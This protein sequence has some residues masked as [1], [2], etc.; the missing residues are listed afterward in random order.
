M[1]R[2]CDLLL[3]KAK[4]KDRSLVALV[5]SYKGS[6]FHEVARRFRSRVKPNPVTDNNAALKKIHE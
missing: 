2:G 3:F 6:V 5:S 4:S 1:Q